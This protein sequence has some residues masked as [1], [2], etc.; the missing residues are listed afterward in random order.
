MV[1]YQSRLL[2]HWRKQQT[3]KDSYRKPTHTYRLLD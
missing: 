1:K 3:T 2:G